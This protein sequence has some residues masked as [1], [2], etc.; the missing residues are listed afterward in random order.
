MPPP[1][2]YKDTHPVL[3]LS[4]FQPHLSKYCLFKVYVPSDQGWGTLCC[5]RANRDGDIANFLQM[6]LWSAN[7]TSPGKTG[8]MVGSEE[9]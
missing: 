5:T 2:T 3:F 8:R 6:L 9:K 4:A 1:D 7:S